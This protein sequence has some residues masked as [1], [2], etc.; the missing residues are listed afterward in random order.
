[1]KSIYELS[2]E[3]WK[4]SI[5]EVEKNQYHYKLCNQSND[6]LFSDLDYHYSVLTSRNRGA[7]FEYLGFSEM[8]KNAKHL[9]SRSIEDDDPSSIAIKGN[10]EKS[11]LEIKHI[12]EL[13]K[14]DNWLYEYITLINKGNKRIRFGLINLG[15]KKMM[16]KQ[17]LGWQEHLDE[18][19]LTAIPSRRFYGY[20]IDRRKNH[21]TANDLL[22]NSWA[23]KEYKIP[24]FCAE[25]WLW[26][27]TEHGLLIC[28]YNQSDIEF[29]R[30]DTLKYPIPGRG[31]ND[32]SI[33]F[34]GAY[35]CNGDPE[36]IA[37]LKPRQS[38]TFGVSKY[39][40]F[41]GDYR[42]GY[43]L[44][45]KHLDQSGHC[46]S[47]EYDPPLHWNELYNL[48][49][50]MEKVGF[51]VEGEDYERYTLEQ[52]YTE[53]Q[54]AKDI[55]AECLY[56][57][58]GWNT[59][60][61]SEIWDEERYGSLQDF[62]NRIHQNYGLK[63]GLHLM[64]NFGS[65]NEK[66][67]F[68]LISQRGVRVVSDP[69]INLYC[70]CANDKW[71]NEKTRRI[72]ELAKHGIDFFMFDFTDFSSF[73]VDNAGCYCKDHG[74]EIP[75]RR[76]THAEGILKVIQNVKE[77]FPNILIEAHQRGNHPYYYQ[78]G[79]KNSFDENWG[80]ECM[81][82]PLEDLISHKAFQLYEY[83]IAYN[84]PL[85]LH[86]NE[87][88]D[89]EN[90]LQFWWYASVARHLGIGGLKDRKSKKY[91]NLKQA[92][93]L[94]KKIKSIL[95]RGSFY[96]IDPLTHL[97]ISEEKDKAVLIT[98][99]LNSRLESKLFKLD[100]AFFDFKIRNVFV[101]DGKYKKMNKDQYELSLNNDKLIE[102]RIQVPALSP[103][104]IIFSN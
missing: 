28:K 9:E 16:F 103:R 12:F 90:L 10:F 93:I 70:V 7:R 1:M 44:Y 84:I 77:K 41:K 25:A 15:F 36:N 79:I 62:S 73:L 83:N 64:M 29:S 82:N 35:L 23:A 87:N 8:E 61:G 43:Y 59:Y 21:F 89:N 98:T 63:L 81:W 51:F 18:Y 68:Y 40:S 13:K 27:N 60:L 66:E 99:N 101:F 85:Y 3:Y 48:G 45:R 33:I 95:T 47:E 71:V 96:G 72:L 32:V 50:E 88:S 19:C 2:N 94:Y 30:F 69:Y 4:L 97:H 38:Y 52:L 14:D 100:P 65:E 11:S 91:I 56:I 86:I 78:H 67:Y 37:D 5:E 31:A 20:G 46:F 6:I 17:R 75:M 34:G 57:D 55:G 39:A 102:F 92:L 49:W 53:A 54:I 42:N 22:I 76:Q 24:G 26:G 58:P 104:I 74:H 80:F